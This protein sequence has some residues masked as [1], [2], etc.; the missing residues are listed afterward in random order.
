MRCRMTLFVVLLAFAAGTTQSLF[1]TNATVGLC[2]GPGT[3]Y[4]HIQDAVNA[5][6]TGATIDV[7]PG[8]Y[9]EQVTIMKALTLQGVSGFS[10]AQDA[11]VITV[12]SG[13]LVTS[14]CGSSS[15][16]D[17][18][19]NNVAAQIFVSVAS[20]NVTI[21]G[22]TVDGTGNNIAGCGPSPSTPW[23]SG[24][25]YHN[26]SG[27]IT[28]NTVRNQYQT[29][30]TDY[31][32]CQNGLAVNVESLG[33][34]TVVI[35]NNS[36]RAYQKNGITASGNAPTPGGPAVTI[37]NNYVVGLAATAMNWPLTGAAENGILVGYGATGSITAN[38]VND[39]IWA[40]D[41]NTT[42]NGNCPQCNAA[43]GILVFASTDITVTTNEVGSSQYGIAIETDGTGYCAGG[44]SCGVADG[45][46]VTGNK[47]VGTQ[48]FDAIDLCS[49]GNTAKTNSL[50]GNTESGVH[51][52]D[53]CSNST[54]AITS[55][56]N[57]TVTGNTINEACA[58]VLTGTGS[59]N[60]VSPNTTYN[61]TNVTFGGD[62]CPVGW[63][64]QSSGGSD[65]ASAKT[66]AKTLTGRPSPLVM[67][68]R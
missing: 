27:T 61:V 52:D 64:P 26:S 5:V 59:G 36:V 14:T 31:G 50:Y 21:K 51:V 19:G 9:P 15:C 28:D 54:L 10:P 47:V 38:T 32:G 45:A 53:T 63:P 39:N 11:A 30:Y 66:S 60:T 48:I 65:V 57:N 29:D 33:G 16:Q 13:G 25:W 23:L 3:H 34:N 35:S 67:G 2:A 17:N 68:K 46:T 58:G 43:S 44:A 8:T 41:L 56:N 62:A 24:I 4:T 42:Y 20:G 49:N 12:P 40:Q 55:G 1:A 18:F 7:C 6:L 22:L 37:T